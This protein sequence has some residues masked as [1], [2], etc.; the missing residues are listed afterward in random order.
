MRINTE[1]E[2]RLQQL[3]T[4]LKKRGLNM[5]FREKQSILSQSGPIGEVLERHLN[6]PQAPQLPELQTGG[7]Y[8]P[9]PTQADSLFLL[10]N[11]KIIQQLLNSGYKWA[12][13][14]PISKPPFDSKKDAIE[15]VKKIYARDTDKTKGITRKG[16]LKDY[17]SIKGEMVG[18][19]DWRPG[20]GDD[21]G[22]PMQYVHPN[23]APQFQGDLISLQGPSVFSYGYEDLA[24]TPWS[25]LTPAQRADRRMLYGDSGT[26]YTG[27]TS[28]S[29]A[30]LS[31][32]TPGPVT[33]TVPPRPTYQQIPTKNLQSQQTEDRLST[34]PVPVYRPR[35]QTNT[36]TAAENP[37]IDTK[38]IRAGTPPRTTIPRKR[39][40]D[41]SEWVE[42]E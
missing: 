37:M 29:P 26:P 42:L 17:I 2:M 11:N 9:I 19:S 22:V 12:D 41:G 20:G 38:A 39:V 28:S 21:K 27:V 18:S 31:T 8:D 7:Q 6:P 24:I 4:E 30:P 1:E 34:I 36:Y 32:P 40:W 10:N 35:F 25:M 16:E 3:D 14:V 13:N 23:I 15:A 33:S 5:T